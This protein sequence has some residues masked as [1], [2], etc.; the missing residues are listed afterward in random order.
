[1]RRA[2]EISEAPFR[3]VQVMSPVQL[4]ARWDPER[5]R[6]GPGGGPAAHSSV[7]GNTHTASVV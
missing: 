7:S 4:D 6:R 1:M 5:V 2:R 3:S